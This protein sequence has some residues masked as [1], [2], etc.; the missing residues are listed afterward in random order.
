MDFCKVKLIAN[1]ELDQIHVLVFD[2]GHLLE[3]YVICW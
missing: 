1:Y 3:L 2:K